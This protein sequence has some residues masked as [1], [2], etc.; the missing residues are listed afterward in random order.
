M[1]AK[2]NLSTE[3]KDD[4]KTSRNLENRSRHQDDI[5]FYKGCAEAVESYIPKVEKLE[6]M[7]KGKGLVPKAAA[8]RNFWIGI[9]IGTPFGALVFNLLFHWLLKVI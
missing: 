2:K 8:A 5:N 3:M 9:A 4:V 1:A 6:E 7:A